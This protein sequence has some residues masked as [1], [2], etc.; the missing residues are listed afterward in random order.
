MGV[1]GHDEAN[2]RAG[3]RQHKSRRLPLRTWSGRDEKAC[4]A[5]LGR[6]RAGVLGVG[7]STIGAVVEGRERRGIKGKRWMQL[8]R[9]EKRTARSLTMVVRLRWEGSTVAR[10]LHAP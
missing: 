4:R 1:Q 7:C 10:Y 8:R 3:R 2:G 9:E 6:V 5:E